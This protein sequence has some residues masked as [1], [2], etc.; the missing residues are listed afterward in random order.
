M[1]QILEY[2]T[3]GKSFTLGFEMYRFNSTTRTWTNEGAF[4]ALM[5]WTPAPAGYPSSNDYLTGEVKNGSSTVVGKLTMGWVSKYLRKATVEI[6]CVAGSE[7]P[8][9]NGDGI[10]WQD[11]FAEVG[12][13][14]TVDVSDPNVA[15]PSGTS[16]SDAEL[17]QAMLA[18]RDASN[19]DA[20]WRYHILAVHFLDSTPRG[21][22]Y[23]A[24]G[25][26]SNNVPRE[27]VGISSHWMIPNTST[28]GLVKG[29]RFGAATKPFYRTAVHELGHAMGLYHNTVDNGFMNTTDVIAAAATPATPFPNNIKWSFAGDDQQR[30]RHFPDIYARPGGT[31]F[32]TSYATT[33]LSPVDMAVDVEGL[34]LHVSALLAAVPLGAPVRVH[35]ELVNA[36][37]EPIL[38]PASLHMKTGFVRGAVVDPAGTVRTFS[39]LVRCIEEHPLDVLE[40]GKHLSQSLTLLRGGDG[41]LFPMPGMHRVIVEVHWDVGGVEYRVVGETSMMVTSAVNDAHAQAA[42]KVLSTPDALLTLVLGGDHI[43]DGIEAIRTALNN[44]VL[45]PHFAYIEAKRLAECFGQRKANLKAAAA[46]IDDSTVMSPAEIK[47]AATLVKAEKRDSEGAKSLAKTL[48]SKANVLNGDAETREMLAAL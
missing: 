15:P 41:A 3:L 47:K 43:E 42:L 16:W 36:S 21:I 26:D 1:T 27:G 18:R 6:D 20:E 22:M 10:D 31:P 23:D 44:P 9:H 40:R 29:Q 38:A 8:L 35:V 24:F 48:K 32:G 11:I 25:T 14:V 33:P 4:T 13:D 30:L 45:R 39:P 37:G 19:L 28:W 17:H 46:L 5:T 12:W 34:E 2:F 7:A